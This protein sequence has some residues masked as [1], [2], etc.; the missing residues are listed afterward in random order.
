MCKILRLQS[1]LE[2]SHLNEKQLK[3]KLE[4]QTETLSNKMEELS[5]LNEQTQSSMTSEMMEVQIKIIELEN[6]KV[7][8]SRFEQS[9]FKWLFYF[10][11]IK[12]GWNSLLWFWSIEVEL[13]QK[14]QEF[15]YREQQLQLA[16]S[17]LQR[18][19]EQ[20]T[21]EKEEREKEAVSWFN[22]LE[23]ESDPFTLD[24]AYC[25]HPECFIGDQ[26]AW[27][28]NLCKLYVWLSVNVLFW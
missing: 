15:Q 2:E 7:G 14:L 11:G 6:V 19:L 22:A 21:E 8:R 25:V 28:I 18:H 1:S 10:L 23:V 20:V 16:K 5:A 12:N 4:I 17:S 26:P 3:H 9:Y 13:E 24:I 27:Y